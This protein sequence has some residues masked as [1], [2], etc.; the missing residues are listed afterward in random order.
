VREDARLSD[1][2][3]Q[4]VDERVGALPVVDARQRLVGLVS[5]VD[6]IRALLTPGAEPRDAAARAVPPAAS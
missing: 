2:A 5:Y 6:V 1:V 3:R 4:F